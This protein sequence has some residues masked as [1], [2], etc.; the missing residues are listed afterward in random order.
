MVIGHVCGGRVGLDTL[1]DQVSVGEVAVIGESHV[2]N[3]VGVPV[4]VRNWSA[5][6]FGDSL[7][8]GLY[9]FRIWIR[10]RVQKTT[11]WLRGVSP[12]EISCLRNWSRN[13][14]A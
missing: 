2:E 7:A 3:A 4:L 14:V 12:T 1:G 11:M 13:R 5:G 10:T 8:G 6:F 9:R